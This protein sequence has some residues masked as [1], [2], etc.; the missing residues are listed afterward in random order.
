MLNK[1]LLMGNTRELRPVALTVQ[2]YNRGAYGYAYGFDS[3]RFGALAPVPFWGGD[4]RLKSLAFYSYEG[5]TKC[6]ASGEEPS[7]NIMVYISGYQDSQIEI[8]G[9]IMGDIF[10]FEKK[11]DQT[12]YLTFDPPRWVLGSRDTQTDL[13][14]GYYVEEVPWE[15]QDAEQ[16][17]VNDTDRV[18]PSSRHPKVLRR[19]QQRDGL[20]LDFSRWNC[21]DWGCFRRAHGRSRNAY[22]QTKHH[23]FYPYRQLQRGLHSYPTTGYH[24]RYDF[25]DILNIHSIQ[26]CNGSLLVSY[27]RAPYA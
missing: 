25:L 27:R 7:H 19:T 22:L 15:A 5:F 24:S 6:K 3:E 17:T 13:R 10:E 9:T 14:R 8:G 23:C 1:E 18:T 2:K 16:G 20:H 21:K 12:V 4:L 11:V 26:R